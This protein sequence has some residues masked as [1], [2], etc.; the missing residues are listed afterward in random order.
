MRRSLYEYTQKE[1]EEELYNHFP[2]LKPLW[3]KKWF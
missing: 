1:K 3:K 2:L